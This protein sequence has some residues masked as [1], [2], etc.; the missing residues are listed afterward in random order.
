[1]LCVLADHPH[2]TAAM[3]DL[4]LIANLLNRC[5]NLHEKP[6]GIAFGRL[7]SGIA[8]ELGVHSL[9]AGDQ[10]LIALR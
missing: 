7:A 8:G 3:D 2:H 9:A 6:L 1:M 5:T 4:A 10:T